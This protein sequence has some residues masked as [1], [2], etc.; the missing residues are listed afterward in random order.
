MEKS[1]TLFDL[2]TYQLETETLKRGGPDADVKPGKQ[3]LK[4]VLNYAKALE[5]V[6]TRNTGNAF[7]L[8][9]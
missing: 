8:M 6:A 1:F 5:V 3:V 7:L 2:Y 9:N 4:N